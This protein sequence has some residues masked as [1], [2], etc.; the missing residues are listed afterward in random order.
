[1]VGIGRLPLYKNRSVNDIP[2]STEQCRGKPATIP[3][4][5]QTKIRVVQL[6]EDIR[7]ADP[8]VKI[9]GGLSLLDRLNLLMSEWFVPD[10]FRV[11]N[12]THEPFIFALERRSV[13]VTLFIRWCVG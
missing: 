2:L 13:L 4:P 6:A 3:S 8:T 9:Y 11:G 1:M 7:I 5:V 12:L 10:G